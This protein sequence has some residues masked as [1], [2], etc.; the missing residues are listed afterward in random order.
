MTYVSNSTI[1]VVYDGEWPQ[2]VGTPEE[3]AAFMGVRPSTVEFWASPTNMRRQEERGGIYSVRVEL[4]EA[5][6]YGKVTA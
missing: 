3:C 4:D 1:Y 6:T 2:V 5:E